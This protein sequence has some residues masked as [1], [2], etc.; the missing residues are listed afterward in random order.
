M[1][2]RLLLHLKM[3]RQVFPFCCWSIGWI[4]LNQTQN[5]NLYFI[6]NDLLGWARYHEMSL[7]K[8]RSDNC[9]SNYFNDAE[10]NGISKSTEKQIFEIIHDDL[11]ERYFEIV[12]DSVETNGS[13]YQW[14]L[15][16]CPAWKS[17][18]GWNP[19]LRPLS[20]F[21]RSQP[22][23]ERWR[24]SACC[25][26]RF[27]RPPSSSGRTS[28]AFLPATPWGW[29]EKIHYIETVWNSRVSLQLLSILAVS[30]WD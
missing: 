28:S 5:L 22:T 25:P 16:N 21:P 24:P 19:S 12:L 29:N 30:E 20:S 9:G 2:H 11:C 15:P 8:Q 18:L 26:G 3:I 14:I 4:C 6:G 10:E 23:W 17:L 1:S 13:T 7:D 27:S